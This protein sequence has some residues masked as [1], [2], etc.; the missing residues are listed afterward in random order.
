MN[1]ETEVVGKVNWFRANNIT[2]YPRGVESV[3]NKKVK[4]YDFHFRKS[5]K[6]DWHYECSANSFKKFKVLK[7]TIRNGRPPSGG[8]SEYR[9]VDAVSGMVLEWG[10]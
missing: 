9:I 8:R 1:I 5:P 6:Y 4:K 3:K 7:E 2:I 10:R